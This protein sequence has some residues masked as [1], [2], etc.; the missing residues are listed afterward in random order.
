MS[1]PRKPTI[2]DRIRSLRLHGYGGACG[3]AAIEINEQV[4]DGRGR[5][6]AGVNDFWLNRGRGVGHV[7]VLYGGRYYDSS[8]IVSKGDLLDYGM[9]PED[10]PRFQHPRMTAKDFEASVLV[11]LD[12]AEDVLR[13]FPACEIPRRSR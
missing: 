13:Y 7:A 4:F 8:G 3:A 11:E 9:L 2:V 12:D 6:V 10:D 5:Y 1:T